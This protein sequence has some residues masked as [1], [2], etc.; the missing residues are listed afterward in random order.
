MKAVIAAAILSVLLASGVSAASFASQLQLPHGAQL[1]VA[2]SQNV[3]GDADI[4][5]HGPWARDTY[6]KFTLIIQLNDGSYEAAVQYMGSFTT[7]AGAPSPAQGKTETSDAR[8]KFAGAYLVHF[9]A[10]SCRSARGILPAVDRGVTAQG[11]LDGAAE[12]SS[13]DLTSYCTNVQNLQVR[14]QK[15]RYQ[16]GNQTFTQTNSG[17]SGDIVS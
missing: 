16:L 4:G 11:I 17:T 12:G 2:T 1:V 8:G 13:S 5:A 15:W 14:D 7:V 3:A 6:N 10:D 9:T